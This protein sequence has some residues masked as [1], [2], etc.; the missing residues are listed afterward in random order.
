MGKRALILV[1]IMTSCSVLHH[2]SPKTSEPT[3]NQPLI[4]IDGEAF[5]HDIVSEFNKLDIKKQTREYE[6]LCFL[7]NRIVQEDGS[8]KCVFKNIQ[9]V[10]SCNMFGV[11]KQVYEGNKWAVF[12]GDIAS[13]VYICT[14]Y[15]FKVSENG[16][17]I[18]V[19]I[20][21]GEPIKSRG[22]FLNYCIDNNMFVVSD[23]GQVVYTKNVQ[24]SLKP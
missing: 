4:W 11:V 23:N 9:E 19:G 2:Y 1:F 14:A 22:W 15:V 18:M 3:P 10:S 17:L 8:S 24:V 7:R 20:V 6:D 16:S 12:I 13:G 5:A 21:S